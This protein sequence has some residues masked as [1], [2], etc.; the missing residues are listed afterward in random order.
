MTGSTHS[1][2]MR[3][4]ISPKLGP[5]QRY[6]SSFTGARWR[7]HRR[8]G[9]SAAQKA[10]LEEQ[11]MGLRNVLEPLKRLS[12]KDSTRWPWLGWLLRR[13]SLFG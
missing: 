3:E 4:G 5:P 13:V 8:S 11:V 2:R 7:W 6:C 12:V 10:R 9:R 1:S